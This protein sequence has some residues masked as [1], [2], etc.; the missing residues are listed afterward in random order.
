MEFGV[1]TV[2]G[3]IMLLVG[4]YRYC[5]I[6]HMAKAS[7]LYSKLFKAKVGIS[8]S[9]A[10][11][12]LVY[13]LTVFITPKDVNASSWINQCDKQGYA[14]IY[15]VQCAAWTLGTFLM[16][17]EYERLLPEARYANQLFWLLNLVSE[18][19]V[20]FVLWN[21]IHSSLFMSVTAIVNLTVNFSLILM[22]CKT[23]RLNKRYR[24]PLVIDYYPEEK[25]NLSTG[26]DLAFGH[27]NTP[28][29]RITFQPKAINV[30]SVC[31][32]QLIVDI[33]GVGPQ[34]KTTKVLKKDEDF[35]KLEQLIAES[36]KKQSL[37]FSESTGTG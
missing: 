36:T 19:L 7:V 20:V 24:D 11:L 14:I 15:L 9:M 35:S 18:T 33:Y 30:N 8:G 5:T 25:F 16:V 29:Y 26:G 13:C 12:T 32:Y 23:S 28:G 34:K 10:V 21:T 3:V 4:T 31:F 27:N 22:A 2:P 1:K 37:F 6:R 17:E